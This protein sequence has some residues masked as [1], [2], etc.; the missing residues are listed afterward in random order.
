VDQARPAVPTAPAASL[1]SEALVD[2]LFEAE[3]D[4]SLDWARVAPAADEE[5][6]ILL[7]A[8]SASAQEQDEFFTLLGA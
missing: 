4:S 3:D 1:A 8:D 6:E 5:L 7:T 2:A